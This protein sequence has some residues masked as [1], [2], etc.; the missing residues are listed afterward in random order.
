MMYVICSERPMK[1]HADYMAILIHENEKI[2]N[3]SRHV[4][5]ESWRFLSCWT[6]H[7]IL[8]NSDQQHMVGFIKYAHL[9][10]AVTRRALAPPC[11]NDRPSFQTF[12]DAR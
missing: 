1:G 2:C 9:N 7:P 4:I 5:Y 3:M 10:L 8:L 6:V 12:N 11:D